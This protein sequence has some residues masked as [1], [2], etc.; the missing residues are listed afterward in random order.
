M[1]QQQFFDGPAMIRDAR[2]HRGGFVQPL[3]TPHQARETKAP[4]FRAKIIDGADQVHPPVQGVGLAGQ[5][6]ASTTEAVEPLAKAGIE[7][8]NERHVDPTPSVRLLDEGLDLFGR[9]LNDSSH[10]AHD[11]PLGVLFD[12]LSD[13]NV[14]PGSQPGTPGRAASDGVSEQLAQGG[15]VGRQA[16]GTEQD[17]LGQGRAT[18]AD[19]LD[20]GRDQ[21]QVALDRNHAAQPQAPL[22]HQGHGHPHHLALFF[23]TNLIGL[24]LT[25]FPWLL[26]QVFVHSLA[27]LPG[28][29]VPVPDSSL[30]QAKGGNNRLH[31]AAMGQQRH[32]HRHHVLGFL[33]SVEWRPF[34]LRKR[35]AADV[36]DVTSF[37]PTMDT[38]LASSQ[39]SSS[40]A[41]HIG[42]KYLLWVHH[43]NPS[44]FLNFK[45]LLMDP[46]FFNHSSLHDSLWSYPGNTNQT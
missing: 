18:E 24:H 10:D 23:D 13:A 37:L 32:H 38:D 45:G 16:V 39:S 1:K 2:R 41:V 27:V 15:D 34:R 28:P 42:A 43:R 22:D 40:G 4:M 17:R 31:R 12:R 7:S 26:D 19:F 6:A 14:G 33:Q 8:F 36:T 11:A 9:A 3:V 20:Q 30:I 35:L 29:L 44:L 21:G 25:D 46:S 5:G